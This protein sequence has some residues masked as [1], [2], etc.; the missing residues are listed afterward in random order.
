MAVPSGLVALWRRPT[1]LL[2]QTGWLFWLAALLSLVLTLPAPLTGN[3]REGALAA[4]LASAALAAS[5]GRRYLRRRASVPHDLVDTVAVLVFAAACPMPAVAF[6]FTFASLWARAIYGTTRRAVAYSL[7]QAAA[8]TASTP[9]WSLVPGHVGSTSPAPVLDA[10]PVLLV[11]MLVARHLALVLIARDQSQRRDAALLELGT[12]L[13]GVTDEEQA[14]ALAWEATTA[15]CTATPGTRVLAVSPRADG[16]QVSGVAGEFAWRPELLPAA[17]L[18][19]GAPGVDEVVPLDG[20][21]DLTAAAGFDGRWVGLGMPGVPDGTMLVG[22]PDG[23]SPDGLVAL[24][25]MMNQV[26]LALR[27]IAAHRDLELQ[28]STDALTGLANR[29][30]F[31]AALERA[32]V[33]GRPA[34][35]LLFVDL[36]DFKSINDGCGHAAGD[37]LLREVADR[38]RGAVRSGDV[39]ARLGGDEFAVLLDDG[40]SATALEIATRLVQL[41]AAPV[42]LAGRA[43]QVGA[44]IGVVCGPPGAG[45]DAEQLVQRADVAMYAAKARGK[46]RVQ[47]FDP[48]LLLLD[49]PDALVAG[50]A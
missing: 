33:P 2:E 34:P 42:V 1:G 47:V 19:G 25:S 8:M 11:T 43:T 4:L 30:A 9:L 12:A 7:L 35:A 37:R 36:D 21:P 41:V 39:C 46:H 22:A 49:G 45:L 23:V 50:P 3:S 13:L 29:S 6:G 16:L 28:A 31:T 26:A 48:T 15:V 17:L 10:L 5:W 18:T 32:L 24:R 44:S 38:M 20:S 14:Y 27:T 40:D